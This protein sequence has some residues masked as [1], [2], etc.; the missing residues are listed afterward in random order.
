V[1]RRFDRRASK[2]DARHSNR[3][4]PF[5]QED[6]FMVA[7]AGINHNAMFEHMLEG[8]RKCF[9]AR[10]SHLPMVFGLKHQHP[11]K[12]VPVSLESEAHKE[13]VSGLMRGLAAMGADAVVLIVEAW[14]L[15][16]A[17]A[18]DVSKWV[19]RVSEHPN[20]V[21]CV[22]VTYSTKGGDR[23]G[24]ANIERPVGEKPRLGEWI[25]F[26]TKEGESST[27]RFAN[28]YEGICEGK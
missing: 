12:I 5:P 24:W 8:A 17:D 11:P 27:G 13:L 4:D 10:G 20:R 16:S 23:C 25:R 21:E 22:Q 6:R 15:E 26:G 2:R 28:C 18:G 3:F 1:L 14:R 9:D 7:I 19:G